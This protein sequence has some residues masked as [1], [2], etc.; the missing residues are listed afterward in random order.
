MSL[1]LLRLYTQFLYSALCPPL[2]VDAHHSSAELPHPVAPPPQLSPPLFP[3]VTSPEGATISI[4]VAGFRP[5]ASAVDF[6]TIPDTGSAVGS[7]P[8]TWINHA[9][10]PLGG[11]CNDSDEAVGY[12]G[13]APLT[14]RRPDH[15]VQVVL[16]RQ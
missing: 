12:R 1:L 6:R 3:S 2:L 9:T 7:F 10:S 5:I 16:W 11:P 13:V 15:R 14:L 4:A 8:G